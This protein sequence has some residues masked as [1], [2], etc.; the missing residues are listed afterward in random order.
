[1][2]RSRSRTVRSAYDRCA[3]LFAAYPL[4]V[5]CIDWAGALHVMV[6][7]VRVGDSPVFFVLARDSSEGK[8]FYSLGPWPPGSPLADIEADGGA[9]PEAAATV[10][11]QGIPLPR[12][13]SL[14]GWVSGNL[15]TALIA[16]YTQYTPEDPEP[17]WAVMP[18]ANLP[19]RSWPPFT[20]EHLF[21]PWFW[22][23]VQ[24]D[25]ILPLADLIAASPST[26]FWVDTE[27][28]L[29][30]DCCAVSRDI[31]N[32]AGYVLPRGCYLYY[33]ALRQGVDVPPLEELLA[34]PAKT[35]LAPRLR[36]LADSGCRAG[37]LPNGQGLYVLPRSA[38][39][40]PHR[41]GCATRGARGRRG[42]E[43]SVV[44][45]RRRGSGRLLAV[46]LLPWLV[47]WSLLRGSQERLWPPGAGR[48]NYIHLVCPNGCGNNRWVKAY[49]P[50]VKKCGCGEDGRVSMVKCDGCSDPGHQRPS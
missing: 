50:G 18:L 5:E 25:A 22:E 49:W 32:E 38:D 41:R 24:A 14:F 19:L 2:A 7:M 11:S 43:G 39:N 30:W 34:G 21:G 42:A 12:H 3:E 29:G 17:S 13:G 10:L 48:P 15:V 47:R 37:E 31:K 27:A 46:A 4:A 44:G 9:V 16:V 20:G 28:A 23:H 33:E 35:D 36:P 8:P 40:L 26:A 6:L 1:M 45:G